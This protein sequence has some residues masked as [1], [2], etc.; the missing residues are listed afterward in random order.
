MSLE[1]AVATSLYQELLK[2][3]HAWDA[4]FRTALLK[5]ITEL[6]ERLKKLEQPND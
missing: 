4:S 6:E 3:E 5:Y 2:A 1:G